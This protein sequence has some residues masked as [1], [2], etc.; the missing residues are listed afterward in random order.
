MYCD[1]LPIDQVATFIQQL[2]G[3]ELT[4]ARAD[5]CQRFSLPSDREA[6]LVV[7]SK[8][9]YV[10]GTQ[11]MHHDL[12]AL[13]DHRL[14]SHGGMSEQPVPFLISHPLTRSYAD[15]LQQTPLNNYD[16]FDFAINGV[17]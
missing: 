1:N 7:V 3:I 10:I 9:H 4:L 16:I 15:R 17:L 5:A 6:D 8:K 14:R 13:G 12:Q 11:R 2:P